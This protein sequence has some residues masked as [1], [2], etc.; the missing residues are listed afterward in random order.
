M[1]NALHPRH[2]HTIYDI[3]RQPEGDGFRSRQNL[4]L[5]ENDSKVDVDD[6]ASF[7]ANEDVV[8][9]PISDAKDVPND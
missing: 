4:P 3:P 8:T 2:A 7:V 1:E 6:V 5:L 9:V